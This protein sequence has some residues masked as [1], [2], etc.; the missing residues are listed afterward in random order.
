DFVLTLDATGLLPDN[1]FEGIL[2]FHHN[3]IGGRTEIAVRLEVTGEEIHTTRT[4]DLLRDWNTVS[5]NLQPD[6]EDVEVLMSDLVEQDILVMMKDGAGHFYRP[7]YDF[8][9]IPGWSVEQGYQIKMRDEAQLTLEGW[10]VAADEPIRLEEGWQLISYYPRSPI[11]ATLALS[12]IEDHLII[13]KDGFGNFYIPAWDYCNMGNMCEGQGYQINVDA[14]VELVYMSERED[15][16]RSC[17]HAPAWEQES[18]YTEPGLLPIHTPTGVNMSLLVL[19]DPSLTGNIGVYASGK[20]VGS[21]V[22]QDGYCGIAVWG[23]DPVTDEIDGAL[24]DQ[25]LEI[26]LIESGGRQPVVFEILSGTPVYQT[27]SFCVVKLSSVTE[28]PSEFEIVSIY[29]NPF[30]STTRITYSLPMPAKVELKLF[31][32]NGREVVVLINESK[33]SGIHTANLNAV[34][35]PSGLYLLRLNASEQTLTRKIM[36]IK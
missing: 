22:L 11:E 15:A 32:L 29:P 6:E 10:S 8:N 25:D 12:G 19:T 5:V 31:D 26:Q 36:L 27:D 34:E 14:D 13:C 2:V 23:D 1:T 17:S 3:G 7:D 30:N 35:L 20:L 4:L 33:Q 16:M 24:E 18:V 9:N 21:G 28:P